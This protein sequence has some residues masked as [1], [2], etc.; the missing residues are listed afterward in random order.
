ML[1]TVTYN[2]SDY[3]TTGAPPA[4]RVREGA[5]TVAKAALSTLK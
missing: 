4:A 3:A 2:G 5:L 1:I